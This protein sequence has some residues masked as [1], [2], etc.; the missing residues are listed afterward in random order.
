[1]VGGLRQVSWAR[2]PQRPGLKLVH[3]IDEPG[4]HAG[5]FFEAVSK[6]GVPTWIDEA[7][8]GSTIQ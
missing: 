1:M 2:S 5:A 3:P 7:A 6:V 4:D 8:S